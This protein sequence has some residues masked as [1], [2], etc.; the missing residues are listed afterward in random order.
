MLSSHP[1][2]FAI[3]G[4]LQL[5]ISDHDL[6]YSIRRNKLPRFNLKQLNIDAW[7]ESRQAISYQTLVTYL[8]TMSMRVLMMFGNI[9]RYF[10]KMS[11][12]NM[13]HWG[14]KFRVI[15]YHGLC[16]PSSMKYLGGTDYIR[17]INETLL[18]LC[19]NYIEYNEIR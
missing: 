13:P 3:F 11:W 16:C 19:G 9:G 15:N 6:I 14:K 18:Q 10:I 17:N 4:T 7:K 8:G 1:D 12:N 5:G 2:R